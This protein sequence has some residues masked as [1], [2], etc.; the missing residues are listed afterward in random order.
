MDYN[1]YVKIS[2]DKILIQDYDGDL[3]ELPENL[4]EGIQSIEHL[5]IHAK[6]I[7]EFPAT[8]N[9]ITVNQS[10]NLT[11][12]KIKL[13]PEFVLHSKNLKSLEIDAYRVDLEQGIT[14]LGKLEN[15]KLYTFKGKKM[16]LGIQQLKGLK[17][18]YLQEKVGKKINHL[19]LVKFLENS[20][21]VKKVY[22]NFSLDLSV[23]GDQITTLNKLPYLQ[24]KPCPLNLH[25]LSLALLKV[26]SFESWNVKT[27]P[28][29]SVV[30]AYNFT[31]LQRKILF[32]VYL[33]RLDLIN[34]LIQN[35]L[36]LLEEN[37]QKSIVLSH[38]LPNALKKKAAE[39]LK[40]VSFKT[41]K[42]LAENDLSAEDIVII[43]SKT[44]LDFVIKCLE[45]TQ[46]IATEDH[47]KEVLSKIESPW[48]NQDE[49]KD[50]ILH[51]Q[52]LIV[53]N[54]TENVLLAL[55]II[56]GGGASSEI[57]SMLAALM[58]AHPDKKIAKESEKLFK[59]LGSTA[60]YD[61]IK[62]SSI[63]LRRSGSS[64]SKVNRLFGQE[65]AL[66]EITF[67]IMHALI[68]GENPNIKDVQDG[69]L[70]INGSI[71]AALPALIS[72]CQQFTNISFQ[73]STGIL[74]NPSLKHLGSLDRLTTLDLSGCKYEI[75]REISGL[76]NLEHLNLT[77]NKLLNPADLKTLQKLTWLS[78]EG[79]Q[80]KDWEFV[81]HL[82]NLK[83]LNVG[84]N[85]LQEIPEAI[86]KQD[87]IEEL[88]LKQNKIKTI[89]ERLVCC[90]FTSIDLSNN[91]IEEINYNIFKVQ[92]L[93][94]LLLRSNKITAFDARQTPKN[95]SLHLLNLASNSIANF[96]LLPAVFPYL[97]TLDLSKNNLTE[98]HD[99]IFEETFISSL[100]ASDNQI[101]SIPKSALTRTFKYL[102]LKNNKIEELPEFIKNLQ[103]QNM[104]LR[105]NKI[106]SIHPS[107]INKEG[108]YSKLYWKLDG[109]P[110]RHIPYE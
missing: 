93:K 96:E 20:S 44:P 79:C 43:N 30:N 11:N 48:L 13:L 106:N 51:V 86:L 7:S 62:K 91:L 102:F 89:P 99:S 40:K 64:F 109:N 78:V 108:D 58:M 21:Y 77:S 83:Y 92:G 1:N 61:Y 95:S 82:P 50:S 80:I 45:Q 5:Y 6:N 12:Y 68:A 104:D 49:N 9:K 53:S 3:T 75:G 85:K 69:H 59:Q 32:A 34:E 101:S 67:R 98:L 47:L 17:S 28:F 46:I 65:I 73:K 29:Q 110:V 76:K 42:V 19:E 18:L 33:E 27:K 71:D 36:D 87:S 70:V 55:E 90:S 8:L 63:S 24:V 57:L 10:I 37:S 23:V 72:E 94:S 22:L 66:D 41:M 14:Q 54:Q 16:P 105:N 31:D 88:I 25:Y 2:A 4:F 74:I 81:R 103:A 107:I 38:R 100:Y 26:A 35:P 39:Y 60:T 84:R 52:R 97:W 15:L 56:R